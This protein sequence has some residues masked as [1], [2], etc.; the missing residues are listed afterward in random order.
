MSPTYAQM[1]LLSEIGPQLQKAVH[2]VSAESLAGLMN[3]E[4]SRRTLQRRLDALVGTG[5]IERLGR[6]RATRYQLTDSGRRALGGPPEFKKP[7]PVRYDEVH[8]AHL[9]DFTLREDGPEYAAPGDP[10][11]LRLSAESLALRDIIR[12]PQAFRQAVGYRREFLD[13]YEP[14]T[15]FYLPLDMRQRLR[16]VGQSP[17]MAG[18]PPGTYAKQVLSRLLIDLSWNSSRLEGN[19]FSLLETEHLLELG[20]SDDPRRWQEAQ[21]ILN[22]KEAIE[23]LTDAPNELGF[24]RFTFLNLHALLSQHLLANRSAEGCLRRIPVG[25]TGTVF[26]PL[27]IPQQ[28]EECFDTLLSKAAAIADPLEQAFFLMVHLPYLQPFEDGNKRTSR[29]AANLPLVQQNL[30]PLSFVDVPAKDYTDGILAVYE[31]NRVELLRD[32]FAWAYERSA[33][34]YAAICHKFG[35]PDAISVGY[36]MEIKEVVNGVVTHRMTKPQAA[37]HI[38]QWAARN[39]GQGDRARFVQAVEELLL[40]LKEGNMARF[41]L[42]PSEFAAWLPVWTGRGE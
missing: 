41:R 2:P 7:V 40:G 23:F 35:E 12:K 9:Y 14:G 22:H 27:H 42:R 38:Q 16:Q 18:L 32:V 37:R 11:S 10:D 5:W 33:V 1:E 31:L 39:I 30:S 4:A 6:A 20:L 3:S 36:R 26:H 8:P 25:V 21:M 15:T 28:I 29:L 24:N 13:S 19:T 34:R 17:E